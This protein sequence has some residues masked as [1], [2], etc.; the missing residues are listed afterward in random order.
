MLPVAE[1]SS[2]REVVAVSSAVA[3]VMLKLHADELAEVPCAVGEHIGKESEAQ[4]LGTM[5]DAAA[6]LKSCW[7]RAT[8]AEWSNAA[9]AACTGPARGGSSISSGISH[10]MPVTPVAPSCLPSHSHLSNCQ[11][12][13][14]DQGR[15]EAQPSLCQGDPGHAATPY[16][17]HNKGWPSVK[18]C[19]SQGQHH[20]GQ[21][22]DQSYDIGAAHR[23]AGFSICTR[24][25]GR[26]CP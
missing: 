13:K 24:A 19:A 2:A 14:G 18:A 16:T 22:P 4:L 3:L 6:G 21:Q 20:N 12:G 8:T 26:L 11:P 17:L 9:A 23:H 25:P 7:D 10:M 15:T 5:A 1:G